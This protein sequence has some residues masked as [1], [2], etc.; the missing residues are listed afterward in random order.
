LLT[1]LG[2]PFL[3]RYYQA[4]Q[5]DGNVIGFCALSEEG[6]PLGWVMGSPKPD[7]VNSRLRE[8]LTWFVM[9][10]LRLLVT[11]PLV[12]GQLVSSVLTSSNQTDMNA[13]SIELTYIGVSEDQSGSG[14]GTKLINHFIEATREAEYHSVVLSVET[15]NQPA[16]ALYEKTGFKI[17]KTFSEGRYQRYRMELSL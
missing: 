8:P 16:L 2:L 9:Q 12:L 13:G 5:D 11:H 6:T 10:L 4:A 7:Q 15:D 14:L 3:E 17:I 1:A